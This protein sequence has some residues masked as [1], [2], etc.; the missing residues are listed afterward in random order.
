MLEELDQ[1][2]AK[3][4]ELARLVQALRTENQQ[5]RAQLATASGELEAMRSRVDEASRRLDGL[6]ERLPA[7]AAAAK[8]PWNT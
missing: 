4:A 7:P 2:A 5:L 3:I 1:L 8:A 6:M